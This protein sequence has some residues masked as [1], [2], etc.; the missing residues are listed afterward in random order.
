M[1]ER[2]QLQSGGF[3]VD[4]PLVADLR[5]ECLGVAAG[6]TS[7][8]GFEEPDHVVRIDLRQFLDL[9][10]PRQQPRSGD[11]QLSWRIGVEAARIY[12]SA[13]RRR[14]VEL[15]N[16]GEVVF[17]VMPRQTVRLTRTRIAAAGDCEILRRW[18]WKDGDVQ[19]SQEA[20]R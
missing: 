12:V 6:G 16:P 1:L 19:P 17:S 2:S 4:N 3:A 8:A 14:L 13:S 18:F 15:R 11:H 7:L 9:Y 5:G 10:A 20:S